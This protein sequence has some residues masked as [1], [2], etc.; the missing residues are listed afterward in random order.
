[1]IGR[2]V[3]DPP[4]STTELTFV[5]LSNVKKGQF[6]DVNNTIGRVT[7]IYK[8][9]RYF[10]SAE[11][12]S[13]L[14]FS[15]PLPK[16]WEYSFATATIIGNIEGQRLKRTV[17]PPAPGEKVEV[18]KSEDIIRVLGFQEEG[19]NLGRLEHHP[20]EVKLSLTRLFQKHLALLA[21]SGAGKSHLASVLIE[22]LL[23]RPKEKGRVAIVAFDMH[24][25]Y[26]GFTED[27]N[28][29]KNTQLIDT[30]EM[31]FS[32]HSI[33]PDIFLSLMPGLTPHAKNLVRTSIKSME[34]TYGL[35]ELKEKIE[36]IAKKHKVSQNVTN[37]IW[38]AFSILEE[39]R[40]FNEDTLSLE[41]ELKPGRLLI[42]DLSTT[43]S[44]YRRQA[45]VSLIAN[46]I[47]AMRKHNN[48]PPT[49][50]LLEEAHNFVNAGSSNEFLAKR[51]I[52][53]I[54][55][56]GRKF[57]ASLFLISQRPVS[58]STT[59]L[60]QC[61]T[62]IIMRI[63][64]PNDL[65]HV[66][67]SA[68]GLDSNSIRTI[69]GLITGEAVIVGEAVNSPVFF[70]VRDRKSRKLSRATSLEELALEYEKEQEEKKSKAEAFL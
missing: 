10:E 35:I 67:T 53:K 41:N 23:D 24:G 62:H 28:Y 18:A 33:S 40:I 54:A 17:S 46:K 65:E 47:F 19:L 68:E 34:G 8:A 63:T 43:D 48:I 58:L 13:D 51:V 15:K 52:E 57:G 32:L 26:L 60:S 5:V 70:K 2:V 59:V 69:P 3:S 38:R 14:D 30:Q 36:E 66:K 49:V 55:R 22:E 45:I 39:E 25:E 7:E 1:M 11:M 50:M 29:S 44:M 64:N 27:E 12:V 6:I 31:T 4:P 20:I 42:L 9:N 61:N 21:M 37:A 16:E 56:E